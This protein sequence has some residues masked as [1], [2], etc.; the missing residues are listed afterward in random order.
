MEGRLFQ[1]HAV[2]PELETRHE[3]RR[4]AQTE[5][6]SPSVEQPSPVVLPAL[7][8]EG[9]PGTF[10][11]RIP[12]QRVQPDGLAIDL[13]RAHDRGC[14]FPVRALHVEADAQAFPD[15]GRA[16]VV[17][18]PLQADSWVALGHGFTP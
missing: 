2:I 18:G 1:W 12:L 17:D 7:F 13:Q 8:V 6:R 3:A 15:A 9:L 10:R 5:V 16:L 11:V 14:H 4:L